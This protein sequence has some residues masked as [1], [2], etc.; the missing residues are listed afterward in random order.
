M[1]QTCYPEFRQGT[2]CY[3]RGSEKIGNLAKDLNTTVEK[4]EPT[5]E[6]TNKITTDV[7]ETTTNLADIRKQ[8]DEILNTTNRILLNLEEKWPF[9]AGSGVKVDEKVKL[10]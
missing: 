9:D 6:N 7:S 3:Q 4:L 8:T 2:Y 5:I 10:P 1:R